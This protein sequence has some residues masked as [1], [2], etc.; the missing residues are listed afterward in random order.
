MQT[1]RR[2]IAGMIGFAAVST[3]TAVA[4]TP[5]ADQS[6]LREIYQQLVEINT[7]D[8][9]GNNTQAAQ[10]MAARLRAAGY[11]DADVQILIP[12]G[13]PKKGNL[14]A[15]LRGTGERR[16]LLLLAHLDVVE[17]KREDWTRDPFKLVEENG[18]FYGRGASDDK[19]MASV[20]VQEMIRLKRE[21]FKPNRDII[22]ALTSDEELGGSSEYN[23]VEFLLRAHRN[24]VDAELALN[25]GG[26]GRVTADGKYERLHIQVSEKIYQD[27]RLQITN[28]GGHSSVPKPDNA[29]YQM[30]EALGKIA[31]FRFPMRLNEATRTFFDR[32]SPISPGQVGVDMKAILTN[33]PDAAAVERLSAIPDLNAQLRTTCVATM[34]DGGH[35]PNA[36]PQRVRATVNCRILPDEQPAAVEK[37]LAGVIGKAISIAPIGRTT[38][39]AG[40]PLKDDIMKPVEAVAAA[41]WPGV[42]VVPIMSAGGTDGRF[43][44][45]IGIRTYGVSGMFNPVETNAHGLNE[46]FRVAALFEGQ[47]FLYRLT[48]MLASGAAAATSGR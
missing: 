2:W 7:T 46:R 12:T 38:V 34:I 42:P 10:A 25:E 16:P 48:K 23:G 43:L 14:V 32:L 20:F 6:M 29:I 11:P 30:S 1:V 15:R 39:S 45:N 3:G 33:P 8:S 28:P 26:G 9:V 5:K 13:A 24:L 47:E 35:A 41:M 40:S 21:G 19:S 18:Y 37:A 44:N 22:L 31:A 4:Q 27:Y 17:A 36:L